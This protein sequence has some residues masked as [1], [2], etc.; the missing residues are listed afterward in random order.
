MR[1]I[2]RYPY[3]ASLDYLIEENSRQDAIGR[4]SKR[5]RE[6]FHAASLELQ[7]DGT[8]TISGPTIMDARRERER[9]EQETTSARA[10][11][12]DLARRV[13][14]Q[15]ILHDC[16]DLEGKSGDEF[17]NSDFSFVRLVPYDASLPVAEY[18]NGTVIVRRRG[19]ACEV[20]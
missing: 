4:I 17:S 13:A 15:A 2:G 11:V 10:H 18:D 12:R 1:E 5:D 16:P 3:S 6:S 19:T 20:R 9:K 7:A 14:I 8:I